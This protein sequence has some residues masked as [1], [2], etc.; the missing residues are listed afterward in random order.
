MQRIVKPKYTEEI[1]RKY[2]EVLRKYRD[3]TWEIQ[4]KQGRIPKPFKNIFQ[5][6][7]IK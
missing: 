6:N 5:K 7:K 2:G 3:T 1:E 4:G